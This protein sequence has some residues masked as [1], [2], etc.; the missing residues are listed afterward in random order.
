MCRAA[1]RGRGESPEC[2]SRASDGICSTRR[3]EAVNAVPVVGQPLAYGIGV[4]VL[5]VVVLTG[6]WGQALVTLAHEGGHYVVG[7][8]MGYLPIAFELEDGGGG[9]TGY[10]QDWWSPG[11][12]LRLFAGYAT[13]PLLGLAGALLV[14]EGM[15]WS[16][17]ILAIVL[18][19]AAFLAATN[20]LAFTVTLI[21]VIGFGWTATAGGPELQAG[22]AVGLVWLLLL[23]GLTSAIGIPRASNDSDVAK[24]T[25]DTLI[26]PRILWHAA[27]TVI[28]VVCLWTGGRALLGL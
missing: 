17:L 21:S 5:L 26:I 2:R 13:P 27:F 9:G 12:I 20:P 19:F 25:R 6:S 7:T 14:A 23:G 22:V 10:A 16:V 8:L 4:L 24:L 15:A 1:V 3:V 11:R 18:L 28:A